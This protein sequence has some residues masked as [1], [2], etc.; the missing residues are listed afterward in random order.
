MKYN[1]EYFKDFFG[2]KDNWTSGT[3]Q[4]GGNYCALGHMGF[5]DESD[6]YK[7]KRA[8]ALTEI[9]LWYI[10][11]TYGEPALSPTPD[12]IIPAVND[13][14]NMAIKKKEGPGITYVRL[15]DIAEGP[16]ERIMTILEKASELCKT[17][18]K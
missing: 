13:G 3:L 16:K 15:N 18:Q 6:A 17:Q 10:R 11:E 12:C 8:K 14:A 5:N 7:S 4:S 1:V 9:L 2:K